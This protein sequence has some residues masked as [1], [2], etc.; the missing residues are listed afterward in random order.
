[1]IRKVVVW[2]HRSSEETWKTNISEVKEQF[3]INGGQKK[4][5]QLFRNFFPVKSFFFA[6]FQRLSF[7]LQQTSDEMKEER[8]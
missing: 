5:D 4:G 7:L 6:F 1:L 3:D 2:Q 8:I